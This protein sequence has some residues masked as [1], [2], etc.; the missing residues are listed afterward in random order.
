MHKNHVAVLLIAAL[1]LANISASARERVTPQSNP[2]FSGVWVPVD[3]GS[4]PPPPPPPPPGMPPPPPPPRTVS[5]TIKQTDTTLT[6][7]RL[8]DV[9]GQHAVHTATFNLDGTERVNQ[10]EPLT[11]RSKA[12]WSSGALVVTS[13]AMHE[14]Q[15]IGELSETYRLDNG[16]LVVETIRVTPAGTFTSK[17]RH[18]RQ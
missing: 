5:L 8:V 12:A 17:T 4:P 15:K 7:E 13:V 1:A 14:G 9:S 2:D 16:S 11:L 6:I 3:G 18:T 10:K